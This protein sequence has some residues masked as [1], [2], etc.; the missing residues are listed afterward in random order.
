MSL[1]QQA[2]QQVS[3]LATSTLRAVVTLLVPVVPF[4]SELG[5]AVRVQGA[6]PLMSGPQAMAPQAPS[7]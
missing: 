3:T 4:E 2:R 5:A 6:S 1:S 7:Q